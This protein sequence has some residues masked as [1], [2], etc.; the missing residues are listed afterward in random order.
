M[1]QHTLLKFRTLLLDEKGRILSNSKQSR[2]QELNVSTDDL[3]DE[4]DLAAA[5]ISQSLVFEL[6]NRER[7]ILSNIELALSRIEA[8]SFGE[9]AACGS[10]IS[11]R[12][13]EARPFT[14]LCVGCQEQ[15]EHREKLYA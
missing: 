15:A 4:V 5:E 12:R 10:E 11:T 9:C 13:L 3:P 2:D 8:G 14:A 7:S 1:D 6:R